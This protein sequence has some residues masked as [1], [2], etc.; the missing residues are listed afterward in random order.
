MNIREM[1]K[2]QFEEF[3]LIKCN[4]VADMIHE[5]DLSLT[6]EQCWNLAKTT[7]FATWN[8]MLEIN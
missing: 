2:E 5:N 7:V 8:P 1:N 3:M 6:R 4:T